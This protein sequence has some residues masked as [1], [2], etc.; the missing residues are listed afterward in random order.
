MKTKGFTWLSKMNESELRELW[1]SKIIT[2]SG[3]TPEDDIAVTQALQDMAKLFSVA[4]TVDDWREYRTKNNFELAEVT[5]DTDSLEKEYV[6]TARDKSKTYMFF[7]E[8]DRNDLSYTPISKIYLW[9]DRIDDEVAVF[10]PAELISAQ[11]INADIEGCFSVAEI[12]FMCNALRERVY[13]MHPSSDWWKAF[14]WNVVNT[15]YVREKR[16]GWVDPRNGKNE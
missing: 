13:S 16:V 7:K 2:C 14:E 10:T 12:R 5:V 6:F 15:L 11:N 4:V 9:G 8:S 1:E 3:T